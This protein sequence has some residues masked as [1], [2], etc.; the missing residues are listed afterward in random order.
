MTVAAVRDKSAIYE[1][2][3]RA[4]QTSLDHPAHVSV[5]APDL[6]EEVRNNLKSEIEA[7]VDRTLQGR[8]PDH[9]ESPSDEQVRRMIRGQLR[10]APLGESRQ[11][12]SGKGGVRVTMSGLPLPTKDRRTLESEVRQLVLK[13]LDGVS[14]SRSR[15]QVLICGCGIFG[16]CCY[17][18]G[19]TIDL[20]QID[21]IPWQGDPRHTPP[22]IAIFMPPGRTKN[23]DD[24]FRMS[25]WA[26]DEEQG[27][28]GIP[29]D[30]MMVGLRIDD[31][32]DNDQWAKE[33]EGWTT[34]VC[35]VPGYKVH[36]EHSTVDYQW[37]MIDKAA[38]DTLAFRK[39]VFGGWDNRYAFD[40]VEF[41]K[42]L[43]GLIITFDWVSDGGWP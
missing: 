8:K 15:Q 32:V 31:T 1:T 18:P 39:A 26:P 2:V 36:Q 41:W 35:G 24:V 21:P 34:C 12:P 27:D 28:P 7:V 30:Q 9:V 22:V 37:M 5:R 25:I 16:D 20:T 38:V 19:H 40:P 13:R 10:S 14:T 29:L 4:R 42:L 33:I 3:L 17:R 43:G 23:F 6:D 11:R